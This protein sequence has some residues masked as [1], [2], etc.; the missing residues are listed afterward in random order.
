MHG[1]EGEEADG[2]VIKKNDQQ[3]SNPAHCTTRAW[4][5]PGR[6]ACSPV[7][8][9]GTVL[10]DA[11]RHVSTTGWRYEDPDETSAAKNC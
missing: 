9:G 2:A 11:G 10:D 1:G 6:H 8:V 7:G 5:R 4:L 3:M